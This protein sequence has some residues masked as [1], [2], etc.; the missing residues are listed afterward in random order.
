MGAATFL[1][2]DA[3]KRANDVDVAFATSSDVDVA[4]PPRRDG[5]ARV[6]LPPTVFGLVLPPRRLST[7]RRRAGG[8][9]AR[10]TDGGTT[11]GAGDHAT[12]STISG[13]GVGRFGASRY[14]FLKYSNA[15][16]SFASSL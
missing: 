11:S 15:C 5:S 1:S 10:L 12:R 8:T 6:T 9:T 2:P 13:G 7:A 16:S 14:A 3:R 4:A